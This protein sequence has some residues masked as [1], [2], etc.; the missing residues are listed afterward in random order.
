MKK[1]L[2]YSFV[3]SVAVLVC[4]LSAPAGAGAQNHA[5]QCKEYA[6]VADFSRAIDA[7]LKAVKRS[8][9]SPDSGVHRSTAPISLP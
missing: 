9:C 6:D 4:F 5:K 7:C 3:V 2:T 1:I 8:A